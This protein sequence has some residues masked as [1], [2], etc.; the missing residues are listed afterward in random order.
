MRSSYAAS[1]ERVDSATRFPVNNKDGMWSDRKP[2]K[3]FDSTPPPSNTDAGPE[4]VVT[5]SNLTVVGKAMVVRGHITSK[6]SLHIEG[7]VSGTL[8]LPGA[9]LTVGQTAK[10][11]ADARAREIEIIGTLSGDLDASKKITVRKGGRLIGDCRTP[12]IVIEEGA[13]YKGKIEIVNPDEQAQLETARAGLRR[14]AA[15]T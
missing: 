2:T 12:G 4:G 14:A 15:G 8:E 1:T 5:V 13:Y 11:V 9:R 3:P 6:E 10:V 7:E